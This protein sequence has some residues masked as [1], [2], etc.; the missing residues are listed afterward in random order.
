[1]KQTQKMEAV[2]T[3]AGG[4][5]HDFNNI[6]SIILGNTELAM[7]DLPGASPAADNLEEVRR[8]SLRARSLLHHEGRGRRDRARAGRG[9]RHRPGP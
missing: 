4:I 3:L 1:M 9:A 8:A 7:M 2:G 6:L 5:A